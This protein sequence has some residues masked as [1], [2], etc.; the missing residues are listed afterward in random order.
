M[1]QG[2]LIT[3]VGQE[4]KLLWVHEKYDLLAEGQTCRLFRQQTRMSRS[5][6][7]REGL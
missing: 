2:K 5:C 4:I 3:Q 7:G 1:F 6:A